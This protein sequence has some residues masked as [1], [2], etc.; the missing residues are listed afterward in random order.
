MVMINYIPF[1]KSKSNEIIGVANLATEILENITP[2]FDYPKRDNGDDE[3]SFKVSVEKLCSS[4]D[5]HLSKVKRFY[6]DC[7]DIDD[8]FQV[9]GRNVYQYL[10]EEL[11]AFPVI[12]V[13]SVDRSSEHNKSVFDL[14]KNN[15]ITSDVVAFRITPE[16]FES[17]ST[18]K[19][20]IF[21]ELGAVFNEFEYVDLVFDCRVCANIDAQKTSK[22]INDFAII[23]SSQFSV[24]NFIVTGSSIPASVA[25][26]L[27]VNEEKSIERREIEIYDGVRRLS[28]GVDYLFGDYTTVSPN[29]SDADIPKNQMQNRTTAKLTY[30]YEDKHYF[31]RGGSLKTI[32]L[33]QYFDLAATLCGKSFFRKGIYSVGDKYLEDKSKRVGS[34]CTPSTIVKPC[35]NAHITYVARQLLTTP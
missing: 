15:I 31:I 29:Y 6:F 19:D 20:D 34:N 30:S 32:G 26:V 12:P 27:S 18:I 3:A 2:F 10:L 21:D 35:V 5:K 14:K 1:L 11:S 4:L 22:L 24:R 9:D 33:G 23:F 7:Y 17:Y 16:D 25:D 28:D 13:V 8:T